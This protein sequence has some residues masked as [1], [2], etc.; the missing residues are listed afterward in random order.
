MKKSYIVL[1]SIIFIYVLPPPLIFV[2]KGKGNNRKKEKWSVFYENYIVHLQ[3]I[4]KPCN[5]AVMDKMLYYLSLNRLH[6]R[7]KSHL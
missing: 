4:R 5:A 7:M 2:I 6:L 3:I 1:I